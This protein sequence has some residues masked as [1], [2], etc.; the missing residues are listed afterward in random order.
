M[1]KIHFYIIFAV[2][3][4][5]MVMLW[6]SLKNEQN[7][8]V[9]RRVIETEQAPEAIGPYSQAIQTGNTLYLAGQIGIDPESGELVSDSL[10]I[11]VWQSMDNLQA[12]LQAAEFSM[13]DVVEVQ[14][15]LTDMNHFSRFN[16]LYKDY[17]FENPPARGVV[18]V[19]RLPLDAKV[20]IK[21]T[22]VKR[23]PTT[24]F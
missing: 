24:S 2:M 4:G 11:Q 13:R 9:V 10:E 8:D 5:F 19:A 23:D 12:V 20:E 21:M 18:E 14:V 16:T 1:K 17:F 15:F 7:P 22:A 6:G 3:I